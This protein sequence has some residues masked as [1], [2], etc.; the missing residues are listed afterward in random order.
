MSHAPE[1]PAAPVAR[2]PYSRPQLRD[3]GS[4]TAI[5]ATLSMDGVQKDGGPNN[6]KT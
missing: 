2:R 1:S 6:L 5:T 3:F 4:V